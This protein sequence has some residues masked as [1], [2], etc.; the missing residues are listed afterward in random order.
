MERVDLNG[1]VQFELQQEKRHSPRFPWA[2]EIRGRFL[3]PL[4]EPELE[5]PVSLQGV[6]ENIGRAGVGVLSDRPL[7]PNSVLRCEFALAGY[8]VLIPTLMR[9]R[10]SNQAEGKRQCKAGLQFL[11]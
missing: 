4:E 9:V 2:V 5:L 3:A 1:L 6:T 8:P 10:W 7:A 11:L